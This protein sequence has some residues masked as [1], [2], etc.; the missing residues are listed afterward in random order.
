MN[1]K[2]LKQIVLILCVAMLALC[3]AACG[4]GGDGGSSGGSAGFTGDK[5]VN[6]GSD[7]SIKTSDLP[8]NYT[9]VPDDQFTAGFK[10]LVDG[11]AST[12]EDVAAAFGD[13]GIRMDGIVYEGYAYYGW[14][15]DKDYLSDTKVNVLVTFKD[16]NGKLSYYAYSANGIAPQDVQ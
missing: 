10:S 8:E 7:F 13:D 2:A 5:Y 14:Y 16:D 15:S 1:K 12:Y 9:L 11:S 3:L 6:D 4:G